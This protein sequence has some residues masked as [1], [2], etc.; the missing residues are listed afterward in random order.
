M[1]QIG[2]KHN[3]EDAVGRR[4]WRCL[5]HGGKELAAGAQNEFVRRYA[6]RGY[7]RIDAIVAIRTVQHNVSKL[8]IPASWVVNSCLRALFVYLLV[9]RGYGSVQIGQ[10]RVPFQVIVFGGHFFGLIALVERKCC[11]LWPFVWYIK[12]IIN[13]LINKWRAK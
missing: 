4:N 1:T 9:E 2:R 11:P 5:E 8:L 10:M 12:N 13:N 6:H 3:I 7:I